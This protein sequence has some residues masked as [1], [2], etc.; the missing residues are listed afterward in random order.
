M[1]AELTQGDNAP[2]FALIDQNGHMVRLSDFKGRKLLIYFYPKAGTSGCTTQ[3]RAVRDARDELES[4]GVS[5]IGISPDAPSAQKKFDEKEAL[6]FPLL[7]DED[8]HVARSYD[9]WGEKNMYGKKF[10]GI[11]RSSFLIGENGRVRNAW[12]KV[13]PKD[14]IPKALKEIKKAQLKP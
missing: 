11:L 9:V 4:L 13:S 2:D 6:G 14:T 1:M 8:R 12:Y 5:V 10:M 7:A 3:A